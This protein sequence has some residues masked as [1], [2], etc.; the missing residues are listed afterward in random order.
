MPTRKKYEV[1]VNNINEK[2]MGKDEI[3]VAF[4]G[5]SITVGGQASCPE[6]KYV[7][8]VSNWFSQNLQNKKINFVNAGVG[9][10]GS[11][12]GVF[13]LN[14]DVI[15][16]NPDMVFIEF[17]V[18][19]MDR[20]INES[21]CTVEGIIRRLMEMKNPPYVF[22]IYT[23]NKDKMGVGQKSHQKIADYYSLPSAD[24]QEH[25]WSRV[26]N[27]EFE[28]LDIMPDGIHPNDKGHKIYADFIIKILSENPKAF[29]K[30]LKKENP[31]CGYKFNN[32]SL[33]S[34]SK[35]KLTG[36]WQEEDTGFKNAFEKAICSN[37]P[38]SSINFEFY[39]RSIG[40]FHMSCQD[41][42]IID[43]YLDG[44]LIKTVDTY[45]N[46]RVPYSL[47]QKFNLENKKHTLNITVNGEKNEASSGRF[48][49]IGYFLCENK[50]KSE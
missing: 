7:T 6:N 22:F 41:G 9:G 42:G 13:R 32:P 2:F 1:S 26:K 27:L 30:P 21:M 34:Y 29:S 11:A 35:A 49:R 38:G 5:G 40:L 36:D 45:K 44:E 17:A 3:T 16:K 23:T 14:K 37:T 25:V 46:M 31:F 47:F 48:I 12:L 15:S 24:L 8:L 4:I 50:E 43:I 28:I 19:D 10:T 39:G 20:D 33:A 18:N